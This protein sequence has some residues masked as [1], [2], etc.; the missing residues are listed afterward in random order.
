[1]YP[2]PW[3]ARTLFM[4]SPSAG[5]GHRSAAASRSGSGAVIRRL[6]SGRAWPL[7]ALACTALMRALQG[8]AAML[9]GGGRV[10]RS[11]AKQLERAADGART[12]AA[13]AQ[14][15]DRPAPAAPPAPTPIADKTIIADKTVAADKT[16][17]ASDK[18]VI[19]AA[20]VFLE[21]E[22]PAAQPSPPPK[23]GRGPVLPPPRR[24]E[25]RGTLKSKPLTGETTATAEAAATIETR[26]GG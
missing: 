4:G 8:L 6:L 14:A 5:E 13:P 16:T 7:A 20:P 19:S 25:W 1:M 23:W 26:S 22:R 21:T 9:E 12:R 18:T 15:E 24:G 11:G 10:I 2:T 3:V 17:V